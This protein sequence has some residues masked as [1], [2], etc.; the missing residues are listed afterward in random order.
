M[1]AN[2][3]Q[4]SPGSNLPRYPTYWNDNTPPY[5]NYVP[6]IARHTFVVSKKS[7]R[8]RTIVRPLWR[9][10]HEDNPYVN[11]LMRR[12]NVPDEVHP[13]ILAQILLCKYHFNEVDPVQLSAFFTKNYGI[14]LY[15][16]QIGLISER[17]DWL[18]HDTRSEWRSLLKNAES[19]FTTMT[20]EDC[21]D[22]R[23]AWR[24]KLDQRSEFTGWETDDP[25]KAWEETASETSG[26]SSESIGKRMNNMRNR[27]RDP[28]ER[29][30]SVEEDIPV[31]NDAPVKNM[32]RGEP[33]V[34]DMTKEITDV[35]GMMA[36]VCGFYREAG[37][38]DRAM[39]EDLSNF[40]MSFVQEEV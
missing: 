16:S 30:Q 33:E 39:N 4:S 25:T 11:K 24:V 21:Y 20:K 26:K 31:E 10:R 17:I 12:M 32:V 18:Q 2:I 9:L 37:E 36:D 3:S 7:G 40:E 5:F 27:D 1:S 34:I 8:T 35:E 13:E 6:A 14:S 23:A 22:L 29:M 19:N 28:E 15:T 38:E